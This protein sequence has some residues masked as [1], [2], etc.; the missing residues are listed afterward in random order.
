M[1]YGKC[2]MNGMVQSPMCYYCTMSRS[3]IPYH[4]AAGMQ[5][6]TAPMQDMTPPK[7]NFTKEEALQIGRLIGVD[8]NKY[9]VEQFR[10]GLNVELEHGRRD[11]Q[12]NVTNDNPILTGKIAYA[13]L[14]E[15]P[16][17]YTK[18]AKIEAM[19]KAIFDKIK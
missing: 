2:P 10:M 17:Y 3:P 15:I 1:Y 11:P 19:R 6:M 7:K 13:H 16:D 14:K 12:T 8:F 18:L 5:D 4:P 9:D